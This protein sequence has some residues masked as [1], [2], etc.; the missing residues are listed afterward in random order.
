MRLIL[1]RP[2]LCAISVAFEAHEEIV[3][4]LGKTNRGEALEPFLPETPLPEPSFENFSVWIS[5]YVNN[6]SSTT[7]SVAESGAAICTKCTNSARIVLT[8]GCCDLSAVSSFSILKCDS[9][10]EPRK[11]SNE[12]GAADGRVM[13]GE[14]KEQQS[15]GP[16]P[17]ADGEPQ[18][19]LN[20]NYTGLAAGWPLNGYPICPIVTQAA[21]MSSVDAPAP[22]ENLPPSCC[23]AK[24]TRC[25][26]RVF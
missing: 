13:A 19:K 26:A 1:P 16:A 24:G 22:H 3:P 20:P 25:A 7:I 2:Q 15:A 5:P 21:A 4:I 11:V 14:M 23:R 8:A 9:A 18:T 6:F 10:D 17:K 12:I